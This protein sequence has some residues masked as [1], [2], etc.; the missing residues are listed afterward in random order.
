MKMCK[1][2]HVQQDCGATPWQDSCQNKYAK[3]SL[4]HASLKI[5]SWLCNQPD[6]WACK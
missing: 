4:S 3:L 6:K 5:I 1:F 2:A